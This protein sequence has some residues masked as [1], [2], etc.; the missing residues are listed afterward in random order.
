MRRSR[1]LFTVLAVPAVALALSL[2][3]CVDE[4][5]VYRDRE[6]FDTPPTGA[7]G[8]LGYSKAEDKLTVCGNCHVGH[9]TK[10][11]ET[12]HAGA[13]QT[14]EAS[15][16][17]ATLCEGCHTVN[18]LGNLVE[19]NGGYQATKDARYEDVQCESCHG[20]GLNH[21]SNPSKGTV[22]SVLAPLTVA[23]DLKTGCGECHSGSHHPF[24]SDWAASAHGRMPNVSP[25][26]RPTCRD[27]HTGE[28][29]LKAWGVNTNFLEKSTVVGD[30]LKNLPIGCAVCHDPHAKN[31]EGQ[32]R[33]PVDVPSEEEN[34]CM[35][36]HHKRG[37]VDFASQNRGPHSPEGPVLLGYGGWWPPNLEIPGGKLVATHG[38]ERNPKLCAGCHLNRFTVT[39]PAT[40]QPLT[41]TGHTF[42]ATPCLDTNGIPVPNGT[43]TSTQRTYRA[44]TGSGCHGSEAVARSAEATAELRVK[45][46]GDEVDRLLMII[47]PNW[48]TC[49]GGNSCGA[50]SQF[51]ST[52]TKF[53]TAE[54]AAFNFELVYTTAKVFKP[55]STIHNPFLVEA[56]LTA[57]IRQLKTDYSI[58]SASLVSL[59]LQL[60]K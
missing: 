58:T 1:A 21:V 55:S 15:G 5:I 28:D 37:Q 13:W 35:K 54:G 2:T 39:D 50:T 23:V 6:L 42:E 4:Q 27:C 19:Q 34:L 59:E 3:G 7:A 47:Q 17:A 40:N 18:Q 9:Q 8:F 41:V 51:N 30:S 12:A 57:T 45:A 48:K 22:P 38:S 14:L 60:G 16:R 32:L 33:F 43:C 49:R 56:L 20:P 25:T 52:D 31:E 53:T 10:W 46:L 44:C 24:V 26:T 36:C 11:Q 29:A